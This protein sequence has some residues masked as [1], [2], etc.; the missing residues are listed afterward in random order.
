MSKKDW[1]GKKTEKKK[2]TLQQ[3]HHDDCDG[4]W[5]D[6]TERPNQVNNHQPVKAIHTKPMSL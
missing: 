1:K 4:Y 5:M 6:E 2:R 3:L